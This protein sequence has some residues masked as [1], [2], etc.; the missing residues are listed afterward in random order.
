ME[1]GALAAGTVVDRYAIEAAVGEGG[2][3]AVFRVRHV[4]LGTVHAL[5]V[6]TVTNRQIRDR[7]IQEGRLQAALQHPNVVSV[8][9]TIDLGGTPGLV[10]EYVDGPTLDDLLRQHRLTLEQ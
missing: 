4:Q 8:T 2:M 3:A 7:L 9:D 6:L 1:A 5:K 10:M